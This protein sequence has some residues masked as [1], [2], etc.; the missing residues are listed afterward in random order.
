MN[1]VMPETRADARVFDRDRTRCCRR[2]GKVHNGTAEVANEIGVMQA[3]TDFDINRGVAQVRH[4][5]SR[6]ED[7]AVSAP[8][9]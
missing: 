8:V 5:G 3:T 1:D 6:R 4:A 9:D 7:S 2:A